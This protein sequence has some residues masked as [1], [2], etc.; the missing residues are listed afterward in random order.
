MYMPMNKVS[1]VTTWYLEWNSNLRSFD[2]VRRY[3]SITFLTP[4]GQFI[5][6]DGL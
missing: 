2:A 6:R 4:S 3:F 5:V 1:G